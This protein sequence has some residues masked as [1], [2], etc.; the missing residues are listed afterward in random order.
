MTTAVAGT[1]KKRSARSNWF[2]GVQSR[3]SNENVLAASA[4]V[5]KSSA[6]RT[7]G[8]VMVQSSTG[9]RLIDSPG[10]VNNAGSASVPVN[11]RTGNQIRFS[12]K[13]GEI[14]EKA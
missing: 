7:P 6:L 12:I 10:T 5:T 8:N 3:R 1:F 14:R 13:S 2:Q 4:L 9:S 11:A